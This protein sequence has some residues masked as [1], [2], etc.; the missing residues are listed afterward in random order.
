MLDGPKNTMD[1]GRGSKYSDSEVKAWAS[2][3]F[4]ESDNIGCGFNNMKQNEE[5]AKQ[6]VFSTCQKESPKKRMSHLI[7]QGE[8]DIILSAGGEH[9]GV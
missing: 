8:E 5:N 3:P 7:D 4:S 1:I 2:Y 9:C 6:R